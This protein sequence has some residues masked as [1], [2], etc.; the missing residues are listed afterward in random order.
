MRP[1]GE[2]GATA[3]VLALS[4]H[5]LPAQVLRPDTL[6]LTLEEAYRIAA[7]SNPAYR[8]ALNATTLNATETRE[9]W[10]DQILPSVNL[11]PISTT[12][13]GRLNRQSVDFF[14]NPVE[15]PQS[16]FTYSSDTRQSISLNWTVQGSNLLNYRTRQRLTNRDRDL[17]LSAAMAD[18]RANV[19][20]QFFTVL[21]E[22]DLL[23]LERS[24]VE[25]RRVDL[26]VAEQLFRLA[27]KTRVD[28]LNAE[29]GIEQ[30]NLAVNQQ[31]R[32]YEQAI[33][34]L[35]TLLGDAGL[36]PL[37]LEAE[38]H[39]VFDPSYLDVD[40]LV[41]RALDA[42]PQVRQQ[43][44]F[45]ESASHGLKESRTRWWPSLSANYT[46]GRRA[47]TNG[48]TALFDLTPEND[49]QS[50]FGLSLSLPFF[51]NYFQN[52]ANIARANVDLDN[53]DDELRSSR[54]RAAEQ[55]RVAA[56]TLRNEYE[57]HALAQRSLEIAQEA[58]RL[59]RE[60]YRLGTRTFEQLRQSIDAEA[61]ARRQ[62]V[63]ADYGFTDGLVTLEDVAGTTIG[64]SPVG[65][66]AG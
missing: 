47:Q 60:E 23:A 44:A 64:G 9:A 32:L 14:G 3:L 52:E 43:Q 34:T 65:G 40:A 5:S 25:S 26:E 50:S 46:F 16:N 8:Q 19:R 30:Q 37:Q 63:E 6:T 20:R 18:L 29:L 62:V 15:N 39:V 36:A 10:F 2:V 41:E 22:R 21:K 49:T 59:A 11:N 28:V 53:A 51:N 61:D 58:L 31:E 66:G 17:A 57:G 48:S 55:V 24:L 45:V 56:L 35:R 33:L 12:Y 13:S 42:N 7:R 38:G 1:W 27:Q 4:I 54:L